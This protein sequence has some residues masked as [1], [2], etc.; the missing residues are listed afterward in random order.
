VITRPVKKRDASVSGSNGRTKTWRLLEL[1]IS[2]RGGETEPLHADREA[3][4]GNKSLDFEVP[5][6]LPPRSAAIGLRAFA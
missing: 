2:T 5:K 6:K 3:G 1:R 4:G